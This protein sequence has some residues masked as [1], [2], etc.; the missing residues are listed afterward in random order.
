MILPHPV[1]DVSAE[2]SPAHASSPSTSPSPLARLDAVG[3]EIAALAAQL[4]AATYHLLERI[5]AFDTLFEVCGGATGF[6]STAHWLAWRTG[7]TPGAA[8]E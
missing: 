3:E 8:R 6:P 4:N 2:T 1:A 5:A 7:L